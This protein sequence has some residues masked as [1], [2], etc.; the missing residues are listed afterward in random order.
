M[1]KEND[2][3]VEVRTPTYRRGDA[4]ACCLRSLQ[5]QTWSNWTCTVYDDDPGGSAEKICAA[6]GDSRIRYH[7]N[8]P[9]HYASRNI[10]QCFSSRNPQ[11]ADY[12]CVVEDDNSILP[13]FFED[14]IR[15]IR[16]NAVEVVL[17]N[18]LIEHASGTPQAR[19]S[20]GGILDG[21]FR[22]GIYTPEKFRLSLLVGIGV[23]NGGLFWTRNSRSLLEIGRFHTT[24][25]LQEYMRTFSICE[26]IY[27]A[28]QPLAVWA[29]NAEQTTR[30]AELKSGYYRRE[31]DLKKSIRALQHAAWKQAAPEDR[32]SFMTDEAFGVSGEHRAGGMAK[33]FPWHRYGSRLPIRKRLELTA[34]GLL[35]GLAGRPTPDMDAF[36]ASRLG[37]TAAASLQSIGP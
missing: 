4:L 11:N 18:Q 29:E 5:A 9:Q 10:D 31:L 23:S 16:E 13:T 33:A 30:N 15:I 6:L 25:T 35:I 12:F 24:A 7:H 34:R 32:K 1:T 8:I 21:L 19:L 36:I 2:G 22:E 26:P 20:E 14:N 37:A 17:R 3:L 28:M 27:V